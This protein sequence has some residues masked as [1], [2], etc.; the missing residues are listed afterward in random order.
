M[1]KY[2][3]GQRKKP[4]FAGEER[5][6]PES[7][8]KEEEHMAN[9]TKGYIGKIGNGGAQVVEAPNAKQGKKGK[10]TVVRGGDLRTGKRK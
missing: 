8:G 7:P 9:S 4:V 5:K 1:H 6:N 3:P 10:T 2:S